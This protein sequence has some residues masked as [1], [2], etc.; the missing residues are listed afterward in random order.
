MN[1]SQNISQLIPSQLP[2]YIRSDPAYSKFVVFLQAYY[3]WMEQQN[4][5]LYETKNLLSYTDIDTTTEEFLQY[6]IQE[7]L[8]YF[9]KDALIEKSLALKVARELY[10][11]KGTISSYQFLFRVLYNSEFDV[12]YTKDAVFRASNG[13]WYAPKSVKLATTDVNFLN[14]KNRRLFGETSKSIAT[15]ETSV[16]SG[17]KIEVFL[18]EVER[19]FESGEIVRVVDTNNQD[20]LVGD[21]PLR[22]KIVG[23]INQV[24]IDPLNRGLL[25]QA[26]DPVI[27]YGGVNPAVELPKEA[28]A[29]I[30]TTTTGSIQKI[31]VVNGGFG[32]TASPNTS[33]KITNVTGALATVGSLTP[34]LPPQIIIA[35]GGSGYQINDYLVS[36]VDDSIFADVISVDNNGSITKVAYRTSINVDA[37]LGVSAN[38]ISANVLAS[39]ASI[40]VSTIL[41]NAS[42]NVATL[43][44]DTIDLKTHEVHAGHQGGFLLGNTSNPVAYN[45]AKMPT[46][47]INT[48]LSEAFTFEAFPTYSISSVIIQNGGGGAFAPP[49]VSASSTYITDVYNPADSANTLGQNIQGI[50][51]NMGILAPIQITNQ[52]SGYAIN[53]KII[54]NGGSGQGAAANVSAVGANG[55]ITQIDYVYPS[56][57]VQYPLGGMGYKNT[58]L[59]VLTANSANGVGAVLS[60]PGILGPQA[61][62]SLTVDRI[63]AITTIKVNEFGEDYVSTPNV[64]IR[65]QDI[66]VSNVS[67]SNLPHKNDIVYQ[68]TSINTASYIATVN[69]VSV[70]STDV[71]PENSKYN[72]RVF[73]YNFNPNPSLQ[74]KFAESTAIFDMANTAFAE[75]EFFIGS[76]EYNSNGY[77]SYGD[78]NAKG[79]ATF[80][81]GLSIGQGE[82]LNKRNH[83]SS[84]SVLQSENYNNYTYQITVEKEISKYREILLNL[85]HPTGMKVLG[86]YAIKSASDFDFSKQ[87]VFFTGKNLANYTGNTNSSISISGSFVNKSNNIVKF[88][89]LDSANLASFISANNTL[90]I[91]PSDGASIKSEVVAVD[92]IN[93]TVTL[94]DN[95]WVTFANVAYGSANSGSNTINVNLITDSYDIVNN[96]NYSNTQNHLVDIIFA[97]DNLQIAGNTYV[98][99]SVDYQYRIIT[100]TTNLS[101]N[102]SNSSISINRTITAGGTVSTISQVEILGAVGG[103]YV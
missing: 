52:G 96:S 63:G 57:T 9:P 77:K 5:T 12:F 93:N 40:S 76:P 32:Y 26:G 59:P 73:N 1:T 102:I 89:N 18:S 31:G 36:S 101:A 87:S 98:V 17:T 70:L 22:A 68:G 16:A 55:A 91:F 6:Y 47:N 54:F 41:G 43:P 8:Q 19:L 7:F 15:I 72:L 29:E 64:S 94:K 100:L 62:F 4:N 66:V 37:L 2:E 21:Q 95:V 44:M 49:T 86:R 23:Q 78:G 61:T 69:S 83:P 97:G 51:S 35:N 34:T 60:V 90:Q 74:L 81:N 79:T 20:V 25:Y 84:F 48:K 80:L 14:I 75:N 67:I 58:A 65:V 27:L 85:L 3:E 103:S 11:S 88:N 82:F 33:I 30:G 38:V 39:N 53:D 92:Y 10:K 50:L 28:I 46:A 42:S 45:F 24:K 71:L 56:A 13:L 99:N